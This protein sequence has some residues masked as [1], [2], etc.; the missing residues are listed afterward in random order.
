MRPLKDGR[1]GKITHPLT[2]GL[3]SEARSAILRRVVSMGHQGSTFT[4]TKLV[5]RKLCDPQ[6]AFET[7]QSVHQRTPHL[8]LHQIFFGTLAK[9]L[10]A[11]LCL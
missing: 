3:P 4:G 6:K 11:G 2:S 10:T 7:L 8:G 9:K 1:G 5:K